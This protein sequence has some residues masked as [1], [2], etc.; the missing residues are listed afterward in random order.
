MSRHLLGYQPASAP[1]FRLSMNHNRT[2][3][4]NALNSLISRH[5]LQGGFYLLLFCVCASPFALAQRQ[6]HVSRSSGRSTA[7]KLKP[8]PRGAL[9]TDESV[10]WQ[11]N[12]VHDGLN[13]AS[14]LVPPLKLKWSRDFSANGVDI[15]SYPLIAEGLV[16]VTTA[17]RTVITATHFGRS[18]K[19]PE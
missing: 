17:T 16:F 7:S 4:R 12:P 15:I 1:T 5:V 3:N 11:N 9:G 13:S 14:P 6:A 19:I 2:D 8:A 10:T 18:M